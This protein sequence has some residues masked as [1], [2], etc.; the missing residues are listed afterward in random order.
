[1]SRRKSAPTSAPITV[2]HA[3]VIGRLTGK[4]T[5]RPPQRL[6]DSQPA[7]A[8]TM[9]HGVA[10][11]GNRDA[12]AMPVKNADPRAPWVERDLPYYLAKVITA[13]PLIQYRHEAS[14]AMTYGWSAVSSVGVPLG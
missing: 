12:S 6:A 9:A 2:A 7:A 8:P 1:A 4:S 3:A 13:S 11:R 14:C 10:S 5:A